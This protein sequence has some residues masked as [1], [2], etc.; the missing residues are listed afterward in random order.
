LKQ[1]GLGKEP[2]NC[3]VNHHTGGVMLSNVNWKKWGIAAL[4]VLVVLSVL[5]FILHGLVLGPTYEKYAEFH[6]WRTPAD[7]EGL[8]GWMYLGYALFAAL[9][10]FVYTRGYEGKP[11]AGEGFRYGLYIG[12]LMYLPGIFIQ[13]A[14]FYWPK[15]ILIG[16]AAG[17]LVECIVCGILVGLLYTKPGQAAA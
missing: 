15:E 1:V 12:L 7:M 3:T 14:V 2:I 5:E 6:F 8:M 4:A 11:G 17:G 9:F 16:M 13:H 10:A